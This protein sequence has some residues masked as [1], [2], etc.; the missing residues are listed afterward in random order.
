MPAAQH[1]MT[2][3]ERIIRTGARAAIHRGRIR[4]GSRVNGADI[5]ISYV[6]V[7]GAED[8][9][10]LWINGQVHGTE[11]CAI[12][13]GLDFCHAIDPAVL[14][15][16][17]VFTASGN[18]LALE[19]RTEAT[20]QDYGANLDTSYP[21]RPNGFITERMAHCLFREILAV[22]PDLLLS[23]HAQGRDFA[24]A[25]YGVYKLPPDCTVDPA[26]IYRFLRHFDPF[27]VCRMSVQ[28]GSGELPGN[29]AGALDYQAMANGIPAFMIELD[30]GQRADPAKIAFGVASFD[31]VARELAML[32]AR[33]DGKG[34]VA[35]R[36][37]T[38]R[39]HCNADSGGLWRSPH[40]P[41]AVVPAGEPIGTI[42]DLTGIV[43]ETVRMPMDVL[44]IAVRLDPVVHTGDGVAYLARE[45]TD[46]TLG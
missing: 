6:V 27:V 15:G 46:L 12:L 36:L 45:W 2:E 16:A 34:A 11:V 4:L 44:I 7:L 14:K 28:A 29:H 9:P 33:A 18:P 35:S 13:A 10:T 38:A 24:S 21:G 32:P 1:D 23:M 30:V 17:V 42:T 26:H 20:Q 39:G 31:R 5:A 43:V 3:I 22:K 19:S 41:G 8:G 37:V 25:V 40:A